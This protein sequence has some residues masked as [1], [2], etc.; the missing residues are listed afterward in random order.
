MQIELSGSFSMLAQL[1]LSLAQ[2]SPSLFVFS[3]IRPSGQTSSEIAR[4]VGFRLTLVKL[5]TFL[6]NLN[7][8]KTTSMEV[9]L[10]G[11]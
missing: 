10:H 7:R 1:S 2:L 6:E 4:N 3:I 9:D 11:R 5:M 8:W